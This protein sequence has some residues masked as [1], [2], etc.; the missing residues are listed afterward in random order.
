MLTYNF[1]RDVFSEEL[2]LIG[3]SESSQQ[4]SIEARISHVWQFTVAGYQP[5]D[6]ISST[7]KADL[8]GFCVFFF[9]LALMLVYFKLF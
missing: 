1:T 2:L 9:L 7:L 6:I 8:S 3:H 5:G 4:D